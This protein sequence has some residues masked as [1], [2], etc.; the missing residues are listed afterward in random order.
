MGK[1]A[2]FGELALRMFY[3]LKNEKLH[4]ECKHCNFLLSLN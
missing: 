4:V 3:D 2:E 1:E